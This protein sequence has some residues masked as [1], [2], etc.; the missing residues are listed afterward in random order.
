MKSNSNSK[1]RGPYGMGDVVKPHVLT[2]SATFHQW[3]LRGVSASR[4]LPTICAHL[5]SVV[6]VSFQDASGKAGQQSGKSETAVRRESIITLVT[7]KR[8]T[9]ASFPFSPC[10]A[11][12]GVPSGRWQFRALPLRWQPLNCREA[13]WIYNGS[14]FAVRREEVIEP[15]GLRATREIV[16][17]P[18]SVVVL[19]V[20]PDGRV[21]LV[22]QYRR[23]CGLFLW[24][25]VAGRKEL[26][27]SPQRGA[28]R[29][30]LEGAG[31]TARRLRIFLDVFPTPGFLTERM[32]ILLVEGLAP[33]RA[34]PEE[35][36]LISSRAF[37]VRHWRRVML[38]S[39]R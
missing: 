32:F 19:P 11:S 6:H 18:G 22:R 1:S 14:L 38:E 3:L 17:H 28:A 35:D 16:T 9:A 4:T 7:T 39:R 26:G 24:E 36:E 10:V 20:L 13:A 25:L 27:E 34:Q 21:L 29:E 5:F 23:A 8:S 30:L 2:Y 37:S 31:Y 12:I 33:G 15:G